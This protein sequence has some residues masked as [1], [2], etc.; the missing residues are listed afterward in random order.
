MLLSVEAEFADSAVAA[1]LSG[2]RVVDLSR[3]VVGAGITRRLADLGAEVVKV[4]PPAVGDRLRLL[5]PVVDGEGL[6]HRVDN[7]NKRSVQ[8]DL[9]RASDREPVAALVQHAH[10]VVES[11]GRNINAA[12]GLDLDQLRAGRPELVVCSVTAFGSSGP[13]A[14]L[15]A[16]ALNIDALA[17][18]Y[19]T[20]PMV[21]RRTYFSELYYGGVGNGAASQDGATAV[22]AA[23]VRAQREGIGAWVE[24]SCWE[25]AVYANRLNLAYRL[26]TG[27]GLMAD[28]GDVIRAP[29]HAVYAAQD[30]ELVYIALVERAHWQTFC[31]RAGCEQLLTEDE[32]LL[33]YGEESLGEPLAAMI[34]T[35]TA[36]E[37]QDAFARWGVPGSALLPEEE[38]LMTPQVAERGLLAGGERAAV[39]SPLTW[40]HERVRS[41]TPMRP[42]P[43]LG[44][45]DLQDILQHWSEAAR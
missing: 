2:I 18:A 39:A 22:C 17:G 5:P 10:V 36:R 3:Y 27:R 33:D 32:K 23:L 15:P 7:V 20:L 44:E 35:R 4:E 12:R 25:S 13:W 42:A 14:K 19:R 29:R 41:G 6:W 31:R 43:D 26:W 28:Q 38:V 9:N 8:A 30:G 16:H 24:V 1:P 21:E 37:W 40:G 34:A 45:A 11:G